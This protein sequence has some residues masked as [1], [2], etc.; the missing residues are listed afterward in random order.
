MSTNTLPTF[1]REHWARF[2][3]RRH[4]EFDEGVALIIYLPESSPEHEIRL[5][6]VNTLVSPLEPLEAVDFGVDIGGLVPHSLNVL[7]VTPSQWERIRQGEL[8]LPDGW[9]LDGN[10]ILQ[11]R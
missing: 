7:D 10:Q 8:D 2:Y 1:D 5:L 11:Q 4:L 6:E 9:T 3:A